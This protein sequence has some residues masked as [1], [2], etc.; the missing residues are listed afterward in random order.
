M[1]L[2]KSPVSGA[3]MPA[4]FLQFGVT[5]S[6]TFLS[7]RNLRKLAYPVGI[8]MTLFQLYFTT[9]FGVLS[10]T[11]MAAIFVSFGLAL[12]FLLRPAVRFEREEDEPGALVV[13]DLCLVALSAACSVWICLHLDEV[14]ERMRYID[15]V[16]PEAIFLGI[17]LVLLTLEGTRRTA[18]LPLS[19]IAGAFFLYFLGGE[20][21]PRLLAH[22]GSSLADIVENMYLQSDGIYGVPIQTAYS[23]L[24]AF[25]MFGAF[26]ER[27]N[28]SSIFMEL[29]C[30]LTKRSQG[31]PAKVAIFASAL[32]GTISGAAASNVYTTGTFTIPLMK[33][34]GYPAYFAGA[35]EAVA[36]TGGQIM[37]PVMGA[38]AFMLAELAQV[39]YLS[40]CK[41]AILPA[42]LFYLALF[43]MIHFRARK[44]ALGYL[45]PELIPPAR[46]VLRK[47]YYLSPLA[48]LLVMMFNG[49][50]ITVCANAASLC[51]FVIS[52]LSRETRFTVRGFFDTLAATARGSLMI[53]ACCACSGIVVGVI[54]HTGLGFKFISVITSVAGNSLFLM[55]IMLMLTSFLLG[56]GMPT[57]PAYIVVA[58]LGAPALIKMGV[59]PIVAHM[60][61]FYYA[62]ISTITPPVCVAAYAGAAIA[63]APPMKTGYTSMKLGIVA[64]IVPL[65]FVYEPALLWQGSLPTV[66]QASVTAVIG[67]IGLSAAMEGWMLRSCAPWERLVLL[68]G[69]LC[70]FYPGSITDILGI[71]GMGGIAI[72]QYLHNRRD[73]VP[74]PKAAGFASDVK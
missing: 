31:G 65:M 16:P 13:L 27:S 37:P 8:A 43:I 1:T 19:L 2:H 52:F 23:V 24:F 54:N 42:A 10:G 20:H 59:D 69:G 30:L 6:G 50:S 26:L 12:I 64:F 74:L 57:T 29:A 73:P 3:G 11:A 7:R 18:G 53:V 17:C 5:M 33:K 41:A 49:R 39:S 62:I 21:L 47:L 40:V 35:V 67:I 32:F 63:D 36:S 68:A 28:M 72:R 70:L 61:V 45:A 38:T 60:F 48:L 22:N 15:P 34:C 58:T 14:M 66:A 4:I 44:S 9:G 55:L 71:A 56:M 51:I 46:Q 25:I